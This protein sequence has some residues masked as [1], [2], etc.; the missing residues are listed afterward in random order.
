MLS[1]DLAV[2]SIHTYTMPRQ[3]DLGDTNSDFSSCRAGHP[4]IRS[5]Y[6]RTERVLLPRLCTPDAPSALFLL[7]QQATLGG[8]RFEWRQGDIRRITDVG[9]ANYVPQLRT[10]ST[11][12]CMETPKSRLRA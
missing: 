1:V 11:Q 5:D 2:G 12:K 4:R 7:G 6:W 10:H 3:S 8:L 9:E